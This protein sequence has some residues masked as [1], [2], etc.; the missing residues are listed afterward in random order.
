MTSGFCDSKRSR[1]S[2]MG[3]SVSTDTLRTATPESSDILDHAWTAFCSPA[4]TNG[5]HGA[6]RCSC[7]RVVSCV[8]LSSAACAQAATKAS[9]ARGRAVIWQRRHRE[10]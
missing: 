9:S 7:E 1:T 4:S 5:T 10:T 2:H 8:L 3:A 6:T